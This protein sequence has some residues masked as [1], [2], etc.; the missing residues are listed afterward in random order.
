MVLPDEKLN[1][2][3]EDPDDNKFFEVALAGKAQYIVSQDKKHILSIKEYRGIKTIHP[4]EFVK[5]ITK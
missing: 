2:V 1:I 5:L 4:E 3:E